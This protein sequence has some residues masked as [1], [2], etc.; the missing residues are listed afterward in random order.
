MQDEGSGEPSSSS[1]LWRHRD[2]RRLWAGQTVSVFGSMI[3]GTALPFTAILALD[4]SAIEVAALAAARMVPELLAGPIAGVWVDR[5]RR[6]PVMIAAD[7]GRAAVLLTVPLAWA[8]DALTIEQLYLVAILAGIGTLFFDVA[9]RSYL[10]SLV[11]RGQLI[12]GNS[13]LTA[14]NAVAEFSG[15]SLGG[16][17]VQIFSGP[18]AIAVDGVSFVASA[19]FL[20]SIEHEEGEP[21]R[22]ADEAGMW[23]EAAAGVR[24]VSGDPLLRSIGLATVLYSLGFGV[25]GATYMLFVTRGLGFETGVLGVIFGLGGI[26]SLLGAVAAARAA[27]TFGLGPS[28]VIGMVMMGA[29]MLF[30][31]LAGGATVV[32]AGMLIAQQIVG[33]GAFTAYDVNSVSL[34]QSITPDA[35]QGRVN[36]SMR[37]TEVGLTLAGT[38]AGGVIGEVLGLRAALTIG[39]VCVIAAGAWLLASPLARVR[40]A[41]LV[42][43]EVAAG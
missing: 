5:L 21:G 33:D 42:A 8:F 13:K 40:T 2:F 17:L 14:T 28:M 26:S 23:S 11:D 39:A 41:P 20:R 18:V 34:R 29:S 15:F 10:P 19:L 9:Y 30:I 31:P 24:T 1:G 36:A 27:R 43:H 38:L 7:V 37:M 3:T 32:A 4:A 16:W 6:R 22:T 35:L 12:D 25:F